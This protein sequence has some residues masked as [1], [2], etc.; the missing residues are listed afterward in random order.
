MSIDSKKCFV[1][2]LEGTVY[3]R[4]GPVRGTVTFIWD[5]WKKAD[6]FFL[7]NDTSRGP[8]ICLERLYALGIPAEEEQ[9]LSPTLSLVEYLRAAGITVA[10]LVGTKEYYGTIKALMPELELTNPA[11]DHM[12]HLLDNILRGEKTVEESQA[13]IV[14]FD[15]ELVYQKLAVAVQLLQHPEVQFLAIHGPATSPSPNGPQPDTGSLLALLEI[16]TMRRPNRLFG[17]PLQEMLDP[18][19]DRFPKSTVAVISDNLPRDK[20]L[21]DN[22]G[23]DF[24]LVLSGETTLKQA[25]NEPEQPWMIVKD[26]GEFA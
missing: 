26:M 12:D 25:H 22:A 4:G 13:V 8:E 1:L 24:I 10:Y 20:A 9:I 23:V 18:V 3:A 2:A 17:A 15:T 5:F 6:F 11:G 7:N 21:A 19:L 14:A 16:A